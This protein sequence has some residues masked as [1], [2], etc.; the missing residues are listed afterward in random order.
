MKKGEPYELYGKRN[1]AG[2]HA[3]GLAGHGRV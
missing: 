3:F 1:R 2:A